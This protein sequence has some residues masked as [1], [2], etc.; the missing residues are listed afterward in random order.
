MNQLYGLSTRVF[1]LQGAAMVKCDADAALT[2]S[3]GQR[4]ATRTPTLDGGAA[5]YDAG[6]SVSDRDI[7]ISTKLDHL[8]F[9][10]HLCQTYNSILVTC[11]DGAFLAVPV[12]YFVRR[13]KAHIKLLI[14]EEV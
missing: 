4:R 8:S 10:E 11:S 7:E 2:N 14:T 9:F 5:V 3:Q 6:Y 12:T 13:S 1:D